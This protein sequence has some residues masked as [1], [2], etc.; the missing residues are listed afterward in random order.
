MKADPTFPRVTAYGLLEAKS[1]SV[2][3]RPE[4]LLPQL[5]D[6]LDHLDRGE[7]PLK[8]RLFL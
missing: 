1:G 5:S 2:A 4:R 7:R 8:T 6:P 3:C